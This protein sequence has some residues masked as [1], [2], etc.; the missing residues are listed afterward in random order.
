MKVTMSKEILISAH[1]VSVGTSKDNV[2]PIIQALCFT[3]EGDNLRVLAT[4]RYVIMSG[5]YRDVQFD[6]W[7][8]GVNVLVDHKR[9]KSVVDYVKGIK[10]LS[11]PVTLED[12]VMSVES[13]TTTVA[14]DT[15]TS[16]F[17]PVAK[18]FPTDTPNGATELRLNV[19]FLTRLGKIIP[20][21][22]RPGREKLW[23]FSFSHNTDNT[24]PLPVLA[25]SAGDD[26]TMQALIQPNLMKR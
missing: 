21:V 20:P 12:G 4:D 9:L 16:T 24:K 10:W 23:E 2:T 8:D 14:A 3:R 1:S 18:L 25:V 26:Y 19:E 5:T 13:M 22:V 17:P 7:E 6:D 15:G 11:V